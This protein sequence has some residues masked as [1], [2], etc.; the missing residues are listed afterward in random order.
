DDGS[1]TEDS[2]K[3]LQA[4]IAKAQ[5]AL[6]TIQTEEELQKAIAEL[7]AAIDGLLEV[8]KKVDTSALETLIAEAKQIS[9]DDGS[10]TEDSFKAL[11]AAIA[12]AEATLK[13][14]N[15]QDDVD[16]AV[17]SLQKAIDELVKVPV[18]DSKQPTKPKEGRE[19]PET[20]STFYNTLLVGSIL[21]LA[22]IILT[23]MTRRKREN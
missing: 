20:A 17:V 21:S 5:E 19:L 9:N 8:P 15:T 22:G 7:Q 12:S 10:Y 2:F 18:E 6:E 1:Y 13:F 16:K 11:Q 23:I 3:A 14:Y 4:A